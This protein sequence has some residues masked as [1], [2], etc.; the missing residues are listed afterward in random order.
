[1]NFEIELK[2]TIKDRYGSVR[3][4]SQA[5]NTPYSTIDNIFKRGVMGVSVQ[6][7]LKICA[8]LNIDVEKI[9]EDRLVTKTPAFSSDAGHLMYEKLD[10]TDK[11]EIRGEIKHMLKSNKYTQ[12]E[13]LT[14]DVIDELQRDV[15]NAVTNIK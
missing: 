9:Q 7:V 2:K 8:E 12:D 3:A 6:V 10:E 15:K 5:I 14:D 1:M 11:A 13:D 4:F